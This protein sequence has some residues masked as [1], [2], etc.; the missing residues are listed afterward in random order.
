MY[1]YICLYLWIGG[2]INCPWIAHALVRLATRKL[3]E[4]CPVVTDLWKARDMSDARP[5][6][7]I[8]LR[9]TDVLMSSRAENH[10][11]CKRIM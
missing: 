7:L 11:E 6:R 10:L 4:F 5:S 8:D 2:G 1:T 9:K 3:P